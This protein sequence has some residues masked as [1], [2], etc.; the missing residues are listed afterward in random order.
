MF[1]FRSHVAG[2]S[3]QFK[4]TKAGLAHITVMTSLLI[5]GEI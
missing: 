1:S 2:Q 5:P 4:G 3:A